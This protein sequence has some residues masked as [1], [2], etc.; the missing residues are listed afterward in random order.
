MLLMQ[1]SPDYLRLADQQ[2]LVAERQIV[3]QRQRVDR[4][5][6]A[7]DGYARSLRSEAGR[8]P[9]TRSNA[10]QRCS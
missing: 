6:A 10:T 9:T 1:D 2:V 4:L 7:G 3:L 5:R 8:L